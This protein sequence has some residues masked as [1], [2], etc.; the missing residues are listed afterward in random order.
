[1]Q[2][3]AHE[4]RAVCP[5][6]G[7][8]PVSVVAL[9]HGH[10]AVQEVTSSIRKLDRRCRCWRCRFLGT[11]A[12]QSSGPCC[13]SPPALDRSGR[14]PPRSYRCCCGPGRLHRHGDLRQEE[15]I[16]GF[17]RLGRVS[18][19]GREMSER[20]GSGGAGGTLPDPARRNGQ[21]VTTGT[22][23]VRPT[24]RNRV[25]ARAFTSGALLPPAKPTL[26][27]LRV[28]FRSARSSTET[29]TL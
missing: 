16:A 3:P 15:L 28:T 29:V 9:G 17:L 24:F 20:Q 14:S 2:A 23:I 26:Q 7:H 11:T 25:H 22:R 13:H 8:P 21:P 12:W 19:S 1:M 4:R 5:G 27:I 18:R 6:V 10:I